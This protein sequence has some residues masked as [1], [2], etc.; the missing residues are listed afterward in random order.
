MG[1]VIEF[2]W[3]MVVANEGKILNDIDDVFYTVKSEKRVYPIG[4]QIPLIIK[5][6]GCIGMIKI[7]KTV[8]DE[9]TTVIYFKKTEQFEVSSP[10]ASHYYDRYLDFKRREAEINP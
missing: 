4:F 1:M 7:V 2:N 9:Q 10:V 5:N 3:F 8:I 6:V